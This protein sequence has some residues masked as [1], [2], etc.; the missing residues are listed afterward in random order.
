M[1]TA[2]TNRLRRDDGFTLIELLCVILIIGILAAVAIPTMLGQRERAQDAQAKH[3]TQVAYIAITTFS[4]DANGYNATPADL[5]AIE[6]SLQQANNLRVV[7]GATSFTVSS[8]S[9]TGV[10]YEV[11]RAAS[12]ALTKRCYPAG[13]AHCPASGLW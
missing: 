6:E 2:M 12:G 5:Y 11:E 10:T 7:G 9:R 13:D 8:D 1:N 3:T 4:L